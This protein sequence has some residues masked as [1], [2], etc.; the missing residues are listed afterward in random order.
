MRGEK[1]WAPALVMIATVALISVLSTLGY[2]PRLFHFVN[3]IPGRD[4]TGHFVLMGLLA[5]AVVPW[6]STV[7]VRGRR[8]GILGATGIVVLL[9]TMDELSQLWL[10]HRGFSFSDLLA[11][12]S[13]TVLGAMAATTLAG[14]R[15]AKEAA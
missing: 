10:P 6:L 13:G 1:M 7:A 14:R 9:I 5:F 11:S 15:E 2:G 3:S 4:L 8:V 12:Y